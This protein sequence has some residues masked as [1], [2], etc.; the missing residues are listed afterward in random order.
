MQL[1]I[2]MQALRWVPAGGLYSYVLNLFDWLRR[3]D[4]PHGLTPVLYGH[5]GVIEADQVR[6]LAENLPGTKLRYFWDGPGL[7]VLSPYFRHERQAAPW[8]IR[9]LDRRIVFPFW[10]KLVRI[11]SKHPNR[12]WLKDFAG[13]RDSVSPPVDLFHHIEVPIF[14]CEAFK[15]NVMTVA[16]MATRDVP[17]MCEEENIKHLEDTYNL[18]ARMDLLLTYSEHTKASIV[19][20]LGIQAGRIHVTPLAAH[21]QY[22]LLSDRD[23]VRAVLAKYELGGR[24]YILHVGTLAPNKNLSRLVEAIHCL[25]QKN[26]T[27]EHQ[28][29]L[30]GGKGWKFE[31]IFETISRFGLEAEVRWLNYASFEDLPALMNGADLFVFPSLYEGFGIPPLEA[32]SCGTPVVVSNATSLPEVVGEAGVLVD[33]YSVADIAAGIHRVLADR[34]LRVAMRY[35]SLAQAKTFSWERTARLTLAAYEETWRRRRLEGRV[36]QLGRS[37][38]TKMRAYLREWVIGELKKAHAL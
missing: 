18:A 6:R 35:K 22:Q 13:A 30:V 23:Q 3:L 5:P 12:F 37:K 8:P 19:K 14:P 38:P 28:L 36:R 26:P 20:R 10:K 4:H 24:P 33:P 2:D 29:V 11:G 27:L 7:H 15:I 34:G 17:Q 31:P 25:K 9:Y 1:G 21:A 16:D 32:M